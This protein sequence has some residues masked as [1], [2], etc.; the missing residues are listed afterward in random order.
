MNALEELRMARAHLRK[1]MD[2]VGYDSDDGDK[3][4]QAESLICDVDNNVC[5]RMAKLL[6][7]ER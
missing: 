7:I 1:A 2:L 4:M 6:G 5:D 3:L